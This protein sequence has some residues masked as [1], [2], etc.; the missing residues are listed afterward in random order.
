MPDSHPLPWNLDADLV[1]VR[2]LDCLHLTDLVEGTCLAFPLR[3]PVEFRQDLV[4]H[5][6]PYP[7]DGGICFERAHRHQGGRP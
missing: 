4:V 1:G 5:D 6:R 2:C 7:G 3:I